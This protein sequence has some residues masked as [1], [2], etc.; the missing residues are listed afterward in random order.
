[1]RFTTLLSAL[2]FLVSFPLMTGC[3]GVKKPEGFPDVIPHTLVV[4]NNGVPEADVSISLLPEGVSGSWA[5][6]GVTNSEGKGRLATS[7]G[8]YMQFGAPVGKYKVV[9][10]KAGKPSSE[11][12]EQ[13]L[14]AMTKEER[15][16]YA[17][18][19]AE[20]RKKMPKIIPNALTTSK[21]PL[22]IE[23]SQGSTETVVELNDYAN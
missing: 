11:K 12:S 2:C 7:Q 9:L 20:E 13:E 1:M 3:G 17:G 6:G 18:K 22:T 16:A 21:T 10:T 8:S 4:N 23:V 5:V 19:I 15:D 14:I